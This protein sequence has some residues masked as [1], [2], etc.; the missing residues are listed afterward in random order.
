MISRKKFSFH[1]LTD[2]FKILKRN[3]LAKIILEMHNFLLNSQHR[4]SFHKVKAKK[5]NKKKSIFAI[6][7]DLMKRI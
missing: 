1:Q 4:I 5:E 3:F 6:L 7:N 2:D